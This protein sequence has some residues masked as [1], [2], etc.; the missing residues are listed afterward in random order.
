MIKHA[1]GFLITLLNGR[2]MFIEEN[3]YE[4][5]AE[6]NVVFQGNHAFEVALIQKGPG[7]YYYD[8]SGRTQ[9]Q[10]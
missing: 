1:D 9:K 7:Q 10:I 3:R 4:E 2:K 5:D 6:G 8:G